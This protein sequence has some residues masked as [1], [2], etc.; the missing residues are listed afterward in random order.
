MFQRNDLMTIYTN[1]DEDSEL[2]I[3]AYLGLMTCPSASIL[4]K[5]KNTDFEDQIRLLSMAAPV[6]IFSKKKEAS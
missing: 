3:A 5:I 6:F 1:R 2:R 4:D